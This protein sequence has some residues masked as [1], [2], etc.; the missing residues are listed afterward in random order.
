[1]CETHQIIRSCR[2]GSSFAAQRLIEKHKILLYSLAIKLTRNKHDAEDLF[3]D[4][5]VKVFRK[6]DSFDENKSFE[7]W[8]YT[9]CLNTYRDQYSKKKRWLNI[10]QDF[11][12]TKEKDQTLQR[13]K[14]SDMSVEEQI[15]H[16][17]E[18]SNL[19]EQLDRL[20][21]TFRI[22]IILYFFH[23][24][25]Y[26]EIAEVLKIPEGTVKSRISLGKKKL[27]QLLQKEGEDK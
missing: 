9:I 24:L 14:N 7:N 1:M 12:S 2:A 25:T 3:Q 27:K 26:K 8:L 17:D 11:F 15:L 18:Q 23:E 10:I 16:S 5:W 4:T 6:L 22:P 20:S 13:I 19:K 21:E